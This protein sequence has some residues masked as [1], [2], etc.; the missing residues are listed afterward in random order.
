VRL[1]GL[2]T[3]GDIATVD[4]AVVYGVADRSPPDLSRCVAA[5]TLR[6]R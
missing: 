3:L 6:A 5:A 1:G 2:E 4:L